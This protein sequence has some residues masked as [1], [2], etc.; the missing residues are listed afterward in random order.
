[1]AL[2][3]PAVDAL[4]ELAAFIEWPLLRDLSRELRTVLD[5]QEFLLA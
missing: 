5:M 3:F 4:D 1:M 2:L